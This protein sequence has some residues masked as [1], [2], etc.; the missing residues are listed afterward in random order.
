[1]FVS[2][3]WTDGKRF[4][5]K[6]LVPLLEGAKLE[7][8]L[9]RKDRDGDLALTQ[10]IKQA[11]EKARAVVLVLTP[12]ALASRWV[13]AE[14]LHARQEGVRVVP[15]K[16]DAALKRNTAGLSRWMSRTAWYDLT[17]KYERQ[18]FLRLLHNPERQPKV[19]F[20][21]PPL[22][23]DFVQR[24]DEFNKLK[25][26]LLDRARMEP[27]AITTALQGA[28]GFGKTTLASALC[29]DEEVK[30]AFGDGILWV[31][32][33]EKPNVVA[34]LNDLC[35]ALTDKNPGF[36]EIG[37]VANRLAELLEDRD[38]LI[39][40][41]DVWNEVHLEPFLRGGKTC[42]RLVTTRRR[43][44]TEAGASRV[45]VDEMTTDQA[46]ELLLSRIKPRPAK[47]RRFTDLARRLGEWPVILS[48]FNGHLRQRMSFGQS[49]T[50]ALVALNEALDRK[51]V[52]A[53]D[54]KQVT[55][56]H[57]SVSL[58]IEVSLYQLGEDERSRY[59]ELAIFPEDEAVPLTTVAALWGTDE[60]ETETLA[61]RV[62]DLAL[63]KLDLSAGAIRLHDVMRH[64]LEARLAN[65]AAVHARP[66]AGWGDPHYLPN[67]Y[68]WRWLG[69]HLERGGQVDRLR[70]LLLDFTF[71]QAKLSAAGIT[72]LI[73]EFAHFPKEADL[74]LIQSA[75]RL[76][77]HILSQDSDQL[78]SQLHGRLLSSSS[79]TVQGF[80][81]DAL[82]G[83]TG[84][85]VRP[86]WPSLTQAG[87]PLLRILTD[88]TAWVF[89]V[90]ATVDG[91]AL[92]GSGDQTVRVWN[93]QS[94][95]CSRVLQGHT[96]V[97]R[98]VAVTHD[99]LALS[100][101]E[102]NTVRVWDLQS[103]ECSRVLQGH[104]GT[105]SA[106]AVSDDGRALSGSDD[107]TVRVWDLQSGKTIA[108]LHGDALFVMVGVAAD[109]R[110][111]I[112]GDSAGQVHF[113]RLE[114][115]S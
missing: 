114:G 29:H 30:L 19:K 6:Q 69:N 10:Q 9:D 94:G 57:Q 25:G 107:Q 47:V 112:A 76:S 26:M 87:G 53:L 7:S 58:T 82:A 75:L 90:A 36:T 102:D 27:V 106:V 105:V 93:L 51:G 80:L 16:A 17:D 98:A 61:L 60:R 85:W 83:Q 4:V 72:S 44:V 115:A 109:G 100:G 20:M 40:V 110:T 97:V 71:L 38:C 78:A 32:L 49:L 48:Q 103:G 66:V 113:L 41:D 33:G 12:S 96:G 1:V 84:A 77:A 70:A 99:G 55:E 52:T 35:S 28:G 59:T 73:D 22:P 111:I 11:I 68:A 65:G 74:R 39:V 15:V 89:A 37:N 43:A 45:D 63:I 13:K 2:Y 95:E 21:A 34:L 88:H 108:V 56:R 91:R 62:A 54:P 46:T 18:N 67:T 64:Y 14:W 86:L 3:S 24:P 8:W 104:T 31:T 79:K 42:A 101:S 81:D 5:T 23:L 50:A 92:S